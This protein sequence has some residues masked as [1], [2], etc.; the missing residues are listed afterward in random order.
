MKEIINAPVETLKETIFREW[1]IAEK[2]EN[3]KDLSSGPVGKI[4]IIFFSTAE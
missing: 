3:V 1:G 2:R 4:F